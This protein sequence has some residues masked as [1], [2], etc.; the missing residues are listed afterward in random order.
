MKTEIQKRSVSRFMI[1]SNEE[2]GWT[3]VTTKKR[4]EKEPPQG[5]SAV[6]P[7][8][9]THYQVVTD[10]QGECVEM[11]NMHLD[12]SPPTDRD[13][14]GIRQG[15][16]LNRTY[17]AHSAF[18]PEHSKKHF[19]VYQF[20]RDFTGSLVTIFVDGEYDHYHY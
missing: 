16:T 11:F 15:L 10:A 5:L 3:T 14:E 17:G 7:D 2:E 19:V 12:L 20:T 9:P 1:M 4:R 18:C 8:I 13:Y 6:L